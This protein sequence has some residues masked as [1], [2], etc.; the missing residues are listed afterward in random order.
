[1]RA[2]IRVRVAAG[3]RAV[4]RCEYLP[5]RFEIGRAGDDLDV[6]RVSGEHLGGDLGDVECEHGGVGGRGGAGVHQ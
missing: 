6:H 4:S 5:N 3:D 1:M 2:R